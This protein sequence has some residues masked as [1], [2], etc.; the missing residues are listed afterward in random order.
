[1]QSLL[2]SFFFFLQLTTHWAGKKNKLTVMTVNEHKTVIG[3]G[4]TLY[5]TRRSIMLAPCSEL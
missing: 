2:F 3:V 5:H 1:M 4:P